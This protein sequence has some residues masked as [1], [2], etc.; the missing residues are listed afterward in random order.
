MFDFITE[1]PAS[2]ISGVIYD[3]IMVVVCRLTKMAH[4]ILARA[5]WNGT[6]LA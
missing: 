1:L 6:E 3:S 4:Y 2:K 5:N